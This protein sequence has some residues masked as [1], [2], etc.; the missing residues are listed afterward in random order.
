VISLIHFNFRNFYTFERA[1]PNE[2][3]NRNLEIFHLTEQKIISGSLHNKEECTRLP[4]CTYG[5]VWKVHFNIFSGSPLHCLLLEFSNSLRGSRWVVFRYRTGQ[6]CRN[7]PNFDDSV[8]TNCQ[9]P[10]PS[11]IYVHAHYCVFCI[12]EGSQRMLSGTYLKKKTST[13][14]H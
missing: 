3:S 11:F 9:E 13:F 1:P 2:V 8:L 5:I 6:K 14:E 10:I 12:V 7:V 4:I